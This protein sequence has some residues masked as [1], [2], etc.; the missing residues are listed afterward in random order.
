MDTKALGVIYMNGF[1]GLSVLTLALMLG[2]THAVSAS[3]KTYI[4]TIKTGKPTPKIKGDGSLFA[5]ATHQVIEAFTD[6]DV[7][8]LVGS[9][10]EAVD[11]LSQSLWTCHFEWLPHLNGFVQDGLKQ[12]GVFPMAG[13][14]NLP[15]RVSVYSSSEAAKVSVYEGDHSVVISDAGQP[16][17]NSVDI[18]WVT[19]NLTGFNQFIGDPK[20]SIREVRIHVEERSYNQIVAFEGDS[21]CMVP[22]GETSCV[23]QVGGRLF[24]NDENVGNENVPITVDSS[25]SPYFEVSKDLNVEWDYRPPVFNRSVYNINDIEG[26]SIV[27]TSG[28]TS[29]ELAPQHVAIIFDSEQT[30]KEGHWWYPQEKSLRLDAERAGN[31]TSSMLIMNRLRYFS[32]PNFK[33]AL[34]AQLSIKDLVVLDGQILHVYETSSIADSQYN[35]KINTR[36]L[37]GQGADIEGE[38]LTLSRF[39][40]EIGFFNA[41]SEIKTHGSL[42]FSNDIVIAAH[43]GWDDGSRITEVHIDGQVAEVVGDDKQKQFTPEALRDLIPGQKYEITAY[44]TNDSGNVSVRSI[45]VDYAEASHVFMTEPVDVFR[46]VEPMTIRLKQTRGVRCQMTTSE[47]LALLLAKPRSYSCLVDWKEIP[48][49][50]EPYATGRNGGIRGVVNDTED[51]TSVAFEIVYYNSEGESVRMPGQRIELDVREPE[52]I[53]LGLIGREENSDGEILI[54]YNTRK[55]AQIPIGFSRGIIDYEVKVGSQ[56]SAYIARPISTRRDYVSG[57]LRINYDSS[58]NFDLYKKDTI[59]V[60]AWYRYRPE[61]ESEITRNTVLMPMNSYRFRLEVG[62]NTGHTQEQFNFNSTIEMISPN[63]WV[64]DESIGGEFLVHLALHTAEG[65]QPITEARPMTAEGIQFSI[66]ASEYLATRINTISAV[67]ILQNNVTDGNREITSNRVGLRLLSGEAI[68]GSLIAKKVE[69]PTPLGVGII[70]RPETRD[71]NAVVSN[72]RWETRLAGTNEWSLAENAPGSLSFRDIVYEPAAYDVRV[73]M[74][75]IM[76]GEET[77]SEAVTVLAYDI[78]RVSITGNSRN[79]AN[80]PAAFGMRTR[81]V[82]LTDEDGVFMWSLDGEIWEQG[83]AEFVTTQESNFTL[84]SRFRYHQTSELVGEEGWMN[85]SVFVSVTDPST[86]RLAGSIPRYAEVGTEFEL[87]GVA[88]ANIRGL[89]DQIFVEW[90]APDGRTF[91]NNAIYEVQESDVNED[92]SVTFILRAWIP[93]LKAETLNEVN[94]STQPWKYNLPAMG[95][96]QRSSHRIGPVTI[97]MFMGHSTIFAPGVTWEYEWDIPEGAKVERELKGGREVAITFEKPGVYDIGATFKDTRGNEVFVQEFIEILEPADMEPQIQLRFSEPYMRPPLSAVM[98]LTAARTHPDDRLETIEWFLN[99]VSIGEDSRYGRFD[100]L[101]AGSYTLSGEI[102]TT[103]GQNVM[104]SQ[105]VELLPNK[106][107]VCEPEVTRSTTS[108]AV[109]ANCTDEDGKISR[110]EWT[111]GGEEQDRPR[112]NYIRFYNV[113]IHESFT[114]KFRAYDDS[115]DYDEHT[116]IF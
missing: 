88:R 45:T 51:R 108:I 30:D 116:I 99:G 81:E 110:Y 112:N 21:H 54:P 59:T 11:G 20:S 2:G 25:D 35:L 104:V 92:N 64:Y 39:P 56:E 97:R 111:W 49:G 5:G 83:S 103:L 36:N 74:D 62:E 63:G 79:Y 78:Q 50:M 41:L 37:Y 90:E 22:A 68:E 16:S 87:S 42:Y 1:F 6:N 73:R 7:C 18:D 65:L 48:D 32:I 8:E 106:P 52:E 26:G 70:Y 71:D 53:D 24:A 91:E 69:G 13:R 105:E 44:A 113:D 66:D 76:T 34:S 58:V 109:N 114:V 84:Y 14:Y 57:S 15:Y 61:L 40:P 19:E 77:V 95:I 67:A 55:I 38:T 98:Q 28:S 46:G 102:R 27:I 72:I 85:A 12:A 94:V 33:A 3:S 9:Q 82:E 43:G 101:E 47:E 100:L 23:T 17:I 86:L 31:P 93:G 96:V 4:G 89:E 107:P 80:L 115:G 29:Y 75:N 60:R 10:Q